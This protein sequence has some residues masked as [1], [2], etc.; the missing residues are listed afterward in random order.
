MDRVIRFPGALDAATGKAEV[1]EYLVEVKS[2][3]I[4][5]PDLR[6][7]LGSV[8]DHRG[9]VGGL[10]LTLRRSETRGLR[11]FCERQGQWRSGFDGKAYAKLQLCS[12]EELLEARAAGEEA[13]CPKL[14]VPFRPYSPDRRV[15]RE[16]VQERAEWH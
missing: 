12:V 4:G 15:G 2:G 8:A 3:R 16:Q 14:P 6:R 5:E 10:M 1:L 11:Q 7:L 9:A 13:P